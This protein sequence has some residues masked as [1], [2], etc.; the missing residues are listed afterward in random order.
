MTGMTSLQPIRLIH[1]DGDQAEPMPTYKPGPDDDASLADGFDVRHGCA[2]YGQSGYKT[3]PEDEAHIDLRTEHHTVRVM[4]RLARD[5]RQGTRR[6]GVEVFVMLGTAEGHPDSKLFDWHDRKRSLFEAVTTTAGVVHDIIDDFA[7]PGSADHKPL[8]YT[9][10]DLL[11]VR[12]RH[13]VL[14]WRG[15]SMGQSFDT[16]VPLDFNDRSDFIRPD[17]FRRSKASKA[18]MGL[19]QFPSMSQREPHLRYNDVVLGAHAT[20]SDDGQVTLTAVFNVDK[21]GPK[22]TFPVRVVDDEVEVPHDAMR[23]MAGIAQCA[24]HAMERASDKK[25]YAIESSLNLKTIKNQ[26]FDWLVKATVS[27]ALSSNSKELV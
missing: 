5:H 3:V 7:D 15:R 4:A 20:T 22:L 8:A 18:W 17:T 10:A 12:I 13:V 27:S 14:A 25:R 2:F 11:G 21:R 26:T 19:L 24:E 1:L 16:D 6:P 9:L 23:W